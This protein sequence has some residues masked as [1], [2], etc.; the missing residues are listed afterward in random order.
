MSLSNHHHPEENISKIEDER[1]NSIA[2]H[3]NELMKTTRPF[4]IWKWLTLA[5]L[6]P[7]NRFQYDVIINKMSRIEFISMEHRLQCL[8]QCL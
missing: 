2:Q 8:L 5:A 1:L 3:P 6:L 7:S 4:E